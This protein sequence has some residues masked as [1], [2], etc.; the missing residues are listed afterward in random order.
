M[1]AG[2]WA[3]G[4]HRAA[5]AGGIPSLTSFRVR[6]LSWMGLG[7]PTTVLVSLEEGKSQA[8]SRAEHPGVG[9]RPPRD[10]A[11][12]QPAKASPAAT[13][14]QKQPP[15]WPPPQAPHNSSTGLALHSP[16]QRVADEFA[17]A[18]FQEHLNVLLPA[19][20]REGRSYSHLPVHLEDA[21]PRHRERQSPGTGK[22]LVV[23]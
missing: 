22:S 23:R 8:G 19:A 5:G 11:M 17:A 3:R 10:E 1:G 6:M 4:T 13:Q 16:S 9:Q 14:R 12:D 7:K 21:Q 2:R 20:K 15:K 18:G